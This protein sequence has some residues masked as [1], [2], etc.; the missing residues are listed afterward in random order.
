M[1]NARDITGV[2]GEKVAE[3]FLRKRGCRIL[4]RRYR[5][6][7]GEID[8]IARDGTTVVFIEVK[9]QSSDALLDPE[10][11]VTKS[12]QAK[13]SRAAAWYV[14]KMALQNNILRF[15]VVTVLFGV[16]KQ[17]PDVQHFPAA[18]VPTDWPH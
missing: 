15:D 14:Q 6:P 10:R 12:K 3:R 1:A 2:A 4:E 5:T 7:V 16:A 9:T 18:F 17:P 13:L 8:L 11:R